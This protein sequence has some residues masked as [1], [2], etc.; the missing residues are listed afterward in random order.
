M[1][2]RYE[3]GA[4]LLIW[5]VRKPRDLQKFLIYG[6]RAFSSQS[7]SYPAAVKKF[8][9]SAGENCSISVPILFHRAS[10]VRSAA[11]RRWALILE[12]AFSMGLKSGL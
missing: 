11:L 1:I 9:H 8:A 6:S 10:R 3:N 4:I 7:G 5:R 2:E 12:K